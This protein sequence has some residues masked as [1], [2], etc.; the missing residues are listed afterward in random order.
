MRICDS[1]HSKSS[2]TNAK[3][4]NADSISQTNSLFLYTLTQSPLTFTHRHFLNLKAL[5]CIRHL[6]ND[7]A[8]SNV[9]NT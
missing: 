6:L 8:M 4:H 9:I 2:A 1:L 3:K 5:Y 7:N